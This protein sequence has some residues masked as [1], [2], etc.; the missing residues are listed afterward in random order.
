M[1]MD[2]RLFLAKGMKTLG[3]D[4]IRHGHVS[5][6]IL[7]AQV[8]RFQWPADIGVVVAVFES[9]TDEIFFARM[10]A[11]VFSD[12][13]KWAVSLSRTGPFVWRVLMR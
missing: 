8:Q 2:K 11:A 5:I 12:S 1:G 13:K 6:S 3:E 9:G 7:T 4:K 10:V